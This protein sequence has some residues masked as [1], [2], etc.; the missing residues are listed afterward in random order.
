MHP[1]E[2]FYGAITRESRYR[3]EKST[4]HIAR[5]THFL[6]KNTVDRYLE[7]FLLA[8]GQGISSLINV[9]MNWRGLNGKG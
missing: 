3:L 9:G 6:D 4:A 7:K 8:K 5:F 1:I 2:H